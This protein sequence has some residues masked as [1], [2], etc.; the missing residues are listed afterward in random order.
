[1]CSINHDLK[2]VFIH[3]HKTGGTYISYMLQKYYGFK[4]YYL[5]RPDHDI[6]CMNKKKTT[7]YLNYENRIHGVL[8][9]FKTSLF[10]NKKMNMTPQKWD[11]YYKFCFI[12]NPYDRI[13]SGWYHVNKL[14]IPFSNYLNLYNRCNDVEFMHVFMPQVRNIINEKGKI[15]I[16]F[17]GQFEN[18]EHDFQKVLKNIGIK[19]IIHEVSKKMNKREHNQFYTY[20]SQEALN[21][22]NLILKEDFQYLN[23]K[24]FNNII[25][26][27]DEY[28]KKDLLLYSDNLQE[29][30][31]QNEENTTQNE[32]NTTQNE[33]NTTQ[34]EENTTQNEENTTQNEEK[35]IIENNIT[36]IYDIINT[37]IE[38]NDTQQYD[39]QQ[40]DTQQYDTQQYD[41]QQ[42][43]NI[44][45]EENIDFISELLIMNNKI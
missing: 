10:I 39:S 33:E 36:Q 22:V 44:N 16:D 1:M 29:N 19:D 40:Y 31:T 4:N 45:S 3:I 26:F 41:T 6:F 28:V 30:T 25:N 17:I 15:N 42:Y 13:I 7:K 23:F 37:N 2:S 35:N 14:N 8:N 34:N 20:F 21:K 24:M 5:R 12:R 27:F 11:T 38:E 9:Y 43:D 18:L 32:E